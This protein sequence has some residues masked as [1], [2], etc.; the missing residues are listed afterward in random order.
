[1]SP[2]APAFAE[3]KASHYSDGHPLDVIQYLEAKLILKPDRFASVEC[4]RQFG[5]LVARSAKQLDKVDF[6][7]DAK[8]SQRPNIREVIFLDTPD[9][10]LYN[11]AFILRRR[12]TYVDGFPD[13]DPEIVFKF[14]HP[15]NKMAA[16]VDVRPNIAGK[17][18]I[19]FK[20]EVLPLKEHIGSYRVLYSHNC[21]FGFSQV[22]EAEPT[23][24]NTLT[25]VF[26]GLAAIQKSPDEK[27]SFVNQAIIEEVL[28]PLG[29]INF[30]KGQVAKCDISLWRTRG[31][32]KP[33]VGEFA[34]QLKFDSAD[35]VREHCRKRVEQFF[36]SLQQD[37]Q[38]WLELGCTK[39]AMVYRLNGNAPPSH[40]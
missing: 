40:E 8:T 1:M 18:R 14:R 27:V 35:D 16:A 20:A 26:P 22:H 10:R 9:A 30:R 33:L 12:I 25:R 6:I 13:G 36:V 29:Q 32:H 19:K 34:F 5:K 4:F 31:E 15:D 21:Q 2:E 38:D 28:L 11:N 37:A 17:Y 23:A 7:P 39:T 24:F 3:K